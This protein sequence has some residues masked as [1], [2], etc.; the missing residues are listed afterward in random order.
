MIKS[1]LIIGQG[2]VL[3][4]IF[5]NVGFYGFYCMCEPTEW[6]LILETLA[7]VFIVGWAIREYIKG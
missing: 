4:W 1:L 5:L 3:L 2:L 6:I 7:S